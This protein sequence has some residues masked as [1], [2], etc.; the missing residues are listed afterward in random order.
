MVKHG[1][2]LKS[3]IDQVESVGKIILSDGYTTISTIK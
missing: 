2:T 1:E 3:G